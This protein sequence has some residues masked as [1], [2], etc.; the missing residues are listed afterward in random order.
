MKL[1]K[2]F[3]LFLLLLS[4]FNYGCKKSDSK[5]DANG[6]N[7][8]TLTIPVVTWGGYAALFAANKGQDPNTDS[9]FYKY[10][11][12][13]VK[14]VQIEDAN[15]H[16]I[17]F[18]SGDYPVIWSTIDMLPI[19]Y[20]S[21]K[22]DPNTIPKVFGVF[23]YSAGGDGIIVRG[24]IKDGKDFKGKK[25]V[26]AQYT[27]SHFFLMWYLN[28]NGLTTN[29]VKMVFV[30]DAIAAKDTFINEDDIDVCVTWSPFIYD[31]TDN[32]ENNKSYI[33]GSKLFMT[34]NPD[35]GAYGVIADVYLARSDFAKAHPDILYA[36]N[37]AMGDGYKSYLE[38]KEE[39]AKYIANIF[40]LKT[41]DAIAM[42]GDVNIDWL[43]I[44][45]DFFNKD[46]EFSGYNL[47]KLSEDLYKQNGKLEKD[48]VFDADEVIDSKFFLNQ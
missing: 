24:D 4:I 48:S 33:P 39:V 19:L 26:V 22:K 42:F 37:K 20:D 34:T 16:L 41:D 13:K 12:F 30:S 10:G 32:S 45:N 23:D 47:A 6:K 28:K 7:V 44:N 36:F 38:N 9:L 5:D 15:Q 14:L 8:I 21:L 25:I 31:L 17:G 27:P 18:S 43:K 46:Y 29:D 1:S 2:F 11:N 35:G 40:G 3:M